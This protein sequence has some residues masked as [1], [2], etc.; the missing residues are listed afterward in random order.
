MKSTFVTFCSLLA[1]VGNINVLAQTAPGFPIQ[2]SSSSSP[3]G[4]TYGSN[5]VSPPGELLPRPDTLNPPN[6]SSS[7]LGSDERGVLLIVDSD[8]PRNGTRVELLHWLVSNVTVNS[9]SNSSGALLIPGPGEAPYWQPS[10][11][12]GDVPH[13]YSFILFSQPDNFSIPEQFNGVLQTRVFFNVSNFVAATGLSGRALAGN[14]IRVQNLTGSATTTFPPPRPT[15][16]TNG[17][18]ST[19]TQTPEPFPGGGSVVVV[20]GGIGGGL[21]MWA[22]IV[23]SL[24]AGIAAVG[25]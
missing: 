11:P 12:V 9:Q 16:G 4:V 5:E 6:I 25:L 3:L 23:G 7:A 20:G 10:P 21:L 13:A 18:N 15:N 2:V 14:Y 24:I 22:M 8:V 17:N 19:G 1:T